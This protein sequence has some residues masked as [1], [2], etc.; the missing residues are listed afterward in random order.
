MLL[1][2]FLSYKPGLSLF[3]VP[4]FPTFSIPYLTTLLSRIGAEAHTWG[5]DSIS[6]ALAKGIGISLVI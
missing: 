2:I 4:L 6:I 3:L 1:S 5:V